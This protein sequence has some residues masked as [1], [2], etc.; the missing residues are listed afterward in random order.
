ML[1]LVYNYDIK[2]IYYYFLKSSLIEIIIDLSNN[3]IKKN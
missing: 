2:A 3:F 1:D